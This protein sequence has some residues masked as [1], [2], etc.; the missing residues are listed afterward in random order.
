VVATASSPNEEIGTY[1]RSKSRRDTC[2]TSGVPSPPAR[3][4]YEGL[5]GKD[6]YEMQEFLMLS[7]FLG[8]EQLNG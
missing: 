4:L 8:R 7:G 1:L 5:Q 2:E 3:D 6:V